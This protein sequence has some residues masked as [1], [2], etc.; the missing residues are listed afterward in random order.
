M[1]IQLAITTDDLLGLVAGT[2]NEGD[3]LRVAAAVKQDLE[4]QAQLAALENIRQN[5]MQSM[6]V[7]QNPAQ[8]KTMAAT[9][10]QRVELA[11]A[12]QTTSVKPVAAK[13]WTKLLS[14]FFL[15]SRQPARWAYL[16][17]LVQ[18]VGITWLVGGT[19]QSAHESAS[20]TRS[21]G[22]ASKQLGEI[23]GSVVISVSFEAATPESAIRG[24]L[25][26][27][28]AQII[29]GPTQLGQY[30]ITVARNRSAFALLKLNEASFVEQAIEVQALS[31]PADKPPS[32]PSRSL[33]LENNGDKK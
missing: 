16:L 30:R 18:A 22:A 15:K 29:A 9:V 1:T 4:L 27:L 11:R 2:L 10:V 6:S 14:N 26:E 3:F 17:V 31:N 33:P 21:A 5:L 12:N 7:P 20:S 28:E 19:F 13:S 23:S 32:E 24:L 25:L 8:A